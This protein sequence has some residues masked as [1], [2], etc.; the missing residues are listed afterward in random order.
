[1]SSFHG[2]ALLGLIVT[3]IMAIIFIPSIF[4]D[5]GHLL[6]E[7]A[8]VTFE[9]IEETLDILIEHLLG[10]GL[11]DTQVIVFYILFSIIAYGCYRIGR[12]IPKFYSDTKHNVQLAYTDSKTELISYWQNM[13]ILN[14]LKWSA[15]G[16]GTLVFL[17][18]FGF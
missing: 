13:S 15:I 2:K 10:T 3:G 12:K 1:M 4:L 17:F 18:F 11:H 16:A 14:K 8:H 5:L 6:I 7:F 9:I